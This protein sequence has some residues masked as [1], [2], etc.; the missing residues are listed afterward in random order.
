MK[1]AIRTCVKCGAPLTYEEIFAAGPFPCPACHTQLQAPDYYGHLTGF[2]S[3]LLTALVLAG[4]GFRGLHLLYAVLIT[5]VPVVYLAINLVK[6]AIPPR[7]EIYL[8]EDTTLHLRDG[9][10]S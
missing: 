10:R 9:P 3:I 8:P 5:L 7:I 6:Y 2:G 4:L 1:R